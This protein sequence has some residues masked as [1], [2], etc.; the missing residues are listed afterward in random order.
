[1]KKEAFIATILG[2]VLNIFLFILKLVFGLMFNSIALISDAI[3]SLTDVINSAVICLAVKIASKK[4]DK[5]HPFGHYRAES[6]AS[7]IVAMSIAIVGFE[8]LKSAAIRLLEGTV[9][10]FGI[11]PI[12]VLMI[13][14]GIKLFMTLYFT[15]VGKKINSPAILANAVDCRN[16]IF[17]SLVALLGIAVSGFG[18][19]Y[20]D[21]I[22]GIAIGCWIIFVGYKL[23]REHIDF[24]M[25][26]R[27][28]QALIDEIEKKALSTKG[29]KRIHD[30]KAHYVGHLVH[31]EIHIELNKKLKLVEA[32]IIAEKVEKLIEEIPSVNKA[33]VHVDPV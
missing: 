13:T 6:I 26:K 22:A 19:L 28:G 18:Y 27:P 24:L 11:A 33:F 23:G 12:I 9:L 31:V 25:G 15:K 10:I 2:I 16:D 32:H 4:A 29:V 30:V 21:S 8:I 17:I 3:N 14:M 1:M 5:D 7:L 20:F